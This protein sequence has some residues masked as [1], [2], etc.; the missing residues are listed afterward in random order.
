MLDTLLTAAL[1][2]TFLSPVKSYFCLAASPVA[3]LDTTRRSSSSRGQMSSLSCPWP[4]SVCWAL[5]P[6]PTHALSLCTNPQSHPGRAHGTSSCPLHR[7]DG[8]RSLVIEKAL[9][10]LKTQ[11]PSTG[12]GGVEP[13][14]PSVKHPGLVGP[15]L[16]GVPET[17]T[18]RVTGTSWVSSVISP[19]EKAVGPTA[20]ERDGN[21]IRNRERGQRPRTGQLILLSKC[22]PPLKH[23]TC[24]R[25]ALC[26][27]WPS[28][29]L[30]SHRGPL[31]LDTLP[32]PFRSSCGAPGADPPPLPRLCS[33][34][35]PAPGT[36]GV[37]LLWEELTWVCRSW[38]AGLPARNSTRFPG[39][40][41][42]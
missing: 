40:E 25:I 14:V 32:P 1:S 24:S 7:S 28:P 37:L 42:L 20:V 26:L 11:T 3:S 19:C 6:F 23:T 34:D 29:Q 31:L 35:R 16:V 21:S 4:C 39:R 9:Y 36:A 38:R 12:R 13:L 22:H 2:T 10:R 18:L 27:G 30:P 41:S 33:E 5:S 15:C 17:P 8:S